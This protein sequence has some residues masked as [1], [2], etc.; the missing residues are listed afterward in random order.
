MLQNAK[1]M[2]LPARQVRI[3]RAEGLAR[4]ALWLL[5]SLSIVLSWI[6]VDVNRRLHT[7][8]GRFATGFA[9]LSLQFRGGAMRWAEGAERRWRSPVVNAVQRCQ[10]PGDPRRLESRHGL[11]GLGRFRAAAAG[12]TS[13][14]ALSGHATPVRGVQIGIRDARESFQPAWTKYT[15]NCGCSKRFEGASDRIGRPVKTGGPYTG[16]PRMLP[17]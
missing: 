16:P 5:V 12:I 6:V 15:N 10:R 3:P 7:S 13:S 4:R 9:D 14:P 11:A 17:F 2:P 8:R 1:R